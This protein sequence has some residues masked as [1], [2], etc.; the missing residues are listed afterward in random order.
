MNRNHNKNRIH[1][2]EEEQVRTVKEPRPVCSL[3]GEPVESIIEAIRE[4]DGSFSH[5][6]CV[7]KKIEQQYNVQAPDKVS[8][9]GSGC[10][11]I[12]TVEPN[13]KTFSIK[14]KINYE[15]VETFNQMKKFVE[16]S[17]E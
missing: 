6:D 10:F 4:N 11:A 13:T 12:V 15:S 8:Y 2:R 9:V 7:I 14:Q 3:C 5:F 17:K 1:E 16:G